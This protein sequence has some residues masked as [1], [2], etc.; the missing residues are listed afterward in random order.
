MLRGWA[1]IILSFTLR[2]QRLIVLMFAALTFVFAVALYRDGYLTVSAILELVHR[3]PLLAPGLFIIFYAAL[4]LLLLPTLPL[5]LAAGFLWGIGWGSLITIAAS[6]LGGAGCFLLARYLGFDF[7]RQRIPARFWQLLERLLGGRDW[8][9]VAFTRL[10]PIFP[11]GLIS[12]AYGLTPVDFRRYLG[13]T[14]VF[15]APLIL[16]FATL[17]HLLGGVVLAGDAATLV[18]ELLVSSLILTMAV[19]FW[20]IM[21]SRVIFRREQLK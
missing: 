17:G 14:I 6:G 12:Y 4:I 9:I 5:N 1:L 3:Y 13:A 18:R 19:V 15:V 21:R 7:L 10:N 2:R 11:F 8:Q 16:L 20:S